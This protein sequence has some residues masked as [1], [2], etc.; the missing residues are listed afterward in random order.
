VY[1]IA[2]RLNA[3]AKFDLTTII[4]IPGASTGALGAAIFKASPK[5][6]NWSYELVLLLVNRK[7]RANMAVKFNQ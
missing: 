4:I 1:A 2:G 3:D 6:G 5:R 7:R